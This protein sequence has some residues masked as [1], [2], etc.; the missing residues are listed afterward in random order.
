MQKQMQIKIRKIKKSVNQ[1]INRII[2]F[3][4]MSIVLLIVFFMVLFIIVKPIRTNLEELFTAPEETTIS[5][6]V[7]KDQFLEV[8]IPIAQQAQIDYGVRP[9][10]LIAQAALESNWGESELSQQSNN[11]FGIKGK[12]SGEQYATKE[13]TQDK[14]QNVQASFRTYDSISD[15]VNDYAKLIKNG[16][17]WN[18]DLYSSVIT[19]E[20]YKDA[21]FALQKAGYATDPNYANKLIRIIEQYTLYELDV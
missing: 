15:S 2:F 7:S 5:E 6:T 19:A 4:K 12:S 11:Y 13:F 10:V 18:A 1:F 20:H 16:T 8:I 9:S 3:G 21:A 17:S 14:W